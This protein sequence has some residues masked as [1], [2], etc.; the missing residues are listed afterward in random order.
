MKKTALS[1]WIFVVLL[2][3]ILLSSCGINNDFEQVIAEEIIPEEVSENINFAV[4]FIDVGQADA[5]LVICDGKAMLIDGGNVDDSRLIYTYLKENN[6]NYLDYIVATHVHEDHMG[7]ISGALNYSDVGAVFCNT[8]EHDSELFRIFKKQVEKAGKSIEVPDM[9]DTF[10]LGSA[11]VSVVS[12]IETENENDASIVLK[13][14]YGNTSFLFTG[15]IENQTEDLILKSGADI[16][17]TVLKVSHHGSNDS[18]SYPFL[19]AV[20]PD[21]AIVSVG[22]DN[23]Y[24][25]PSESVLK[26]LRNTDVEYYRTDING[27]VICSSNGEIVS[28]SF[29]KNTGLPAFDDEDNKTSVSENIIL[30]ADGKEV[31]YVGNKSSKKLHLPSCDSVKDMKEKNREYF[32]GECQEAIELGYTMCGSCKP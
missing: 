24:G 16:K 13:I 20:D 17:S 29:C 5:A 15:D 19:L 22:K 8:A 28:F 31:T 23:E 30:S 25:H 3:G 26:R 6:I 32:F 9:G 21:Y 12:R 1:V 2:L 10:S 18:T 14:V 11:Q 7:G 4:H 27:S